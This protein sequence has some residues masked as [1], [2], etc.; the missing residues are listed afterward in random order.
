M[1]VIVSTR[2]RAD[3]LGLCL[4]A[5]ICQQDL[6]QEAYEVIVVD[7]GSSDRTRQVVEAAR[8]QSN[9]IRYV[10][11]ERLGLSIARNTGVAQAGG[12]IIC[13]IDD[14]AIP[15]PGCIAAIF[16]SFD[17]PRVACV[18][19]KIVASWPDGAV[20]DWFTPRY[21]HVVAQTSFGETARWLKKNEFPFGANISFRKEILQRLGGFDENLGKR[22]E[23]NIWG[24]EIDLCQ[25]LQEDGLGFFYN[26]QA[27]VSH[28]V[29]PNRA[30]RRYFVDTIFGKGVTE[31][32]QKL[33]H[34]GRGIFALYLLLKACRLAIV[35]TCYLLARA[36][37]SEA[38]QFRLRCTIAWCAG[39]L[40]FL[41]VRDDLGSPS[42]STD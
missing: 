12:E 34:K 27:T 25:R 6:T 7:N 8:Q 14:D 19:G 11:E 2:N 10:R 13:F 38:R 16:S 9:R 29:G 28:I 22:G 40:H 31:G 42:R 5:L 21:A 15:A 36:W 18:G 32:Y 17:D 33:T 1:S 20:P 24:E 3:Q 35:S 39:Y 41:A 26:P 37:L 4:D 23:N 30:T